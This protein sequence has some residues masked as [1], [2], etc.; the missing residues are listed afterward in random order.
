MTN[1][2]LSLE[3]IQLINCLIKTINKLVA[4]VNGVGKI[5]I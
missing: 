1:I 2:T 3:W 5:P 4:G